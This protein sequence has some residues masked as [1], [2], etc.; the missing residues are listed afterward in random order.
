MTAEVAVLNKSA[1]ALA[2]DSAVTIVVDGVQKSY[3]AD[4]LFALK[5]NEP[6]GVMFFGN[7]EFMGRPWETLVH[8]YRQSSRAPRL[9]SIRSY[10]VDFLRFIK[11]ETDYGTDDEL[12]NATRIAMDAI[13]VCRR[14]VSDETREVL[15]GR[16][17][18]E[19]RLT[20]RE[21]SA[22][23]K[24]CLEARAAELSRTPL[25]RTANGAMLSATVAVCWDRVARVIDDIFSDF[26]VT[27]ATRRLLESIVR[28]SLERQVMSTSS[29][30]L[31]LAGF[32]TE[33]VFPTLI[34]VEVDGCVAGAIRIQRRVRQNIGRTHPASV[35]A[36]A[37]SEMVQLFMDGVD[38]DFMGYLQSLE[39]LVYNFGKTALQARGVVTDSQDKALRS[40]AKKDVGTYMEGVH[41][42]VRN[43]FSGPVVDVV[44]HLPSDDLATMAESLVSLTSLKRR[45]SWEPETVAGPVNVAVLSKAGFAWAKRQV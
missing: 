29:S 2:A 21:R 19:R 18:Q 40:A 41:R 13:D 30:G 11:N 24:K 20:S 7:A 37:Q 16:D 5:E 39:D 8:M 28:L 36:F 4:K 9:S 3:Q 25:F 23:F 15:M 22:L 31:V 32:G 27:N 38:P 42:L 14:H 33:E 26:R 43:R 6:I 45:V 17:A 12:G 10:I 1:V 44:A 34:S 35:M